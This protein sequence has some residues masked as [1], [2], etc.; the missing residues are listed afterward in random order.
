MPI[1][2]KYT[3]RYT[4]HTGW[5]TVIYRLQILSISN[6]EILEFIKLEN[7]LRA[8]IGYLNREDRIHQDLNDLGIIKGYSL[9]GFYDLLQMLLADLGCRS[10]T[11]AQTL[12]LGRALRTLPL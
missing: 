10:W 4:R 6:T 5:Q 7:F 8:A 1:S 11:Y 3:I 2:S 9:K 12:Y